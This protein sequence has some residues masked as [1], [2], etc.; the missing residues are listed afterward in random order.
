MQYYFGV[1]GNCD[2]FEVWNPY[3]PLGSLTKC[4]SKCSCVG[5]KSQRNYG[6]QN[7]MRTGFSYM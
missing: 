7:F 6:M 5:L 3:I 2:I 4:M 1:D